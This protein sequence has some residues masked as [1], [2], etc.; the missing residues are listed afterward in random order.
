MSFY[1]KDMTDHFIFAAAKQQEKKKSKK[2]LKAEEDA[3]LDALLGGM[4]IKADAGD[5]KKKKE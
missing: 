1:Q 5:D 3:E 2:Q 4:D